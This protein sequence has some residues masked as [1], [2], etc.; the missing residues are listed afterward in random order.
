MLN[1][2]REELS[3]RSGVSA[4]AIRGFEVGETQLMRLN[5]QAIRQ[6]FEAAGIQFVGLHGVELRKQ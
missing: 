4:G 5:H 3:K 1:W 2:T 6:T